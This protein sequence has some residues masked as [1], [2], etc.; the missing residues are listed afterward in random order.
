MSHEEVLKELELMKSH[1]SFA[2]SILEAVCEA[3]EIDMKT[4][5]LTIDHKLQGEL[6]SVSIATMVDRW[7]KMAD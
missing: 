1:L 4:T 3:V 2:V 5:K 6:A 7:R